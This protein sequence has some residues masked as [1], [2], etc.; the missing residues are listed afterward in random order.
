MNV[1][2]FHIQHVIK[3]YGQRLGRRSLANIK[4][5]KGQRQSPDTIEI[6]AEA[7]RKQLMNEIGNGLASKIR[8]H[9]NGNDKAGLTLDEELVAKIGK[10]FKG[11]IDIIPQKNKKAGFK[12]KILDKNSKEKIEELSFD[13]LRNIIERLYNNDNGDKK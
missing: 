6:S 13:D 5:P 1:S 8:S 3:A 10:K 4:L 7:K 9:H 2:S 12:F 11:Q